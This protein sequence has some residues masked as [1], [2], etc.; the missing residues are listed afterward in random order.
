M[1]KTSAS[2]PASI[3]GRGDARV[4]VEAVD[5]QA[6]SGVAAVVDLDEVLG[7]GP[8]AVLGTEEGPQAEAL[9]ARERDGRVHEPVR[10]RGRIGDEA[11]AQASQDRRTAQKLVEAGA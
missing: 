8:H 7:V 6:R 4:A 1:S 2:R 9:H 5:G 3:A 10:H 11:E